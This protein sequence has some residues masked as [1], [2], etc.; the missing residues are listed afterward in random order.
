M[1]DTKLYGILL[2]LK[3]PWSV[4][5]VI[6]NEEELRVDVWVEHP[7]K[8]KWPCPECATE[9]GVLDH[10][11]ERVWRHLD[12]CQFAT[13]LHA[14][15]PRINCPIHGAKQV[16]V[17]WAEP[18]SRFTLMFEHL[19]IDVLRECSITGAKR[20]L[21]TSW[22]KAWGIMERA[23]VRG[24]ERKQARP[25]RHIGVDEKAIAK[26]HKYMTLVCDLD[27]H[28]VDYV[29]KER[30]EAALQG[31]YRQLTPEQRD[32]IEAVAMDMWQPFISA[33]EKA[34]P[35]AEKK[36]VH[37]RFHIMRDMGEAVDEI[38]RA[39]HKELLGEGI[40]LLKHTKYLWLANAENIPVQRRAE[41]RNLQA[42]N[43][44]SSRAWAIKEAL[45]EFWQYRYRGPA[46]AFLKRWYWWA[47]HSRLEPV[48]EVAKKLKRHWAQVLNY[49]Q[50]RITTAVCEGFNSKIQT[51]KKMACGFRNAE[52]FK[53]AIFFHCGGMDLYPC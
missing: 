19:A 36:I 40:E 53:T 22:D 10:A 16:R 8:T 2:G 11:E 48:I 9:Y 24:M 30:E 42:E 23:V 20:I 43:L 5:Q 33:T 46:E 13:F 15:I 50:H 1:Q 45:R 4:S 21:R 52:N 51:V 26:G 6:V 37:D 29:S 14:R 41:F 35:E 49:C 17:P 34:L 3:A 39:E 7:E 27:H 32:A 28:T 38:R 44:K 12:S 47:T 18:K 25:A 31:Y